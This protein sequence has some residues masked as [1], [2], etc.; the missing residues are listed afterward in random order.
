MKLVKMLVLLVLLNLPLTAMSQA[1]DQRQ[2]FV[3]MGAYVASGDLARSEA[4]YQILFGRQPVIRLDDFIA[5]DIAGGWFAI[6]SRGRY[7]PDAISG[8]GAVPYIEA[9]DLEEIRQRASTALN[10]P[11]PSII[12]EP[13]IRLLKLEDPDG[14]L[15]EFFSLSAE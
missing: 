13:G 2:D 7:A 8:S 10:G 9:G 6:V 15:I 12:V 11:A 1:A 14:Q 5:F 4:F 3:R